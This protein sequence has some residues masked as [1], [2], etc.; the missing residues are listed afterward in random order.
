M[1]Q[2][3]IG[4]LKKSKKGQIIG[5]RSFNGAGNLVIAALN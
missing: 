4:N 1:R 2:E 3:D 5:E